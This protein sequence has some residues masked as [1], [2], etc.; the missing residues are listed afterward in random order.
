MAGAAGA[1]HLCQGRFNALEVGEL[2]AHVLELVFAQLARLVTVHAVVEL[3]QTSDLVETEAQALGGFDELQTGNVIGSV[4]AEA[5]LWALGLVQ[6]A[7][8]LVE[9]NGFDIDP[10]GSGD[11]A[12]GY[13]ACLEGLHA[14]TRHGLCV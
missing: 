3:E 14:S 11:G 2:G 6:Q 4:P 10:S 8:A 1:D 13:V 12:D 5:T 7:F 9:A